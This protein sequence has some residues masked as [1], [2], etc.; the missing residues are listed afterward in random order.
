MTRQ[1]GFGLVEI[2]LVVVIVAVA[3]AVL[4]R[5]IASTTGTLETVQRQKPLSA[6]RLTADRATASSLRTSLQ[7][8]YAQHGAYPPTKEDVS[9][10]LSPAPAFQCEGNDYRY[11]PASGQ[12][13]LVIDDPARC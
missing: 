4:Y 6:A 12:V 1:G 3:G 9:A 13:T 7:L 5:Y 10:L 2:L 8:Y 11:D